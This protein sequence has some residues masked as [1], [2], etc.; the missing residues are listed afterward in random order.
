MDQKENL[1]IVEHGYCSQDMVNLMLTGI[2][3][4]NVFDGEQRFDD[5]V[6]KGIYNRQEFGYLT[7]YEAYGSI[8]VGQNYKNP[9]NEIYVINSESHY[10]VMFQKL[11]SHAGGTIYYYYDGLSNQETEI[12]LEI[13]NEREVINTESPLEK[14][15]YTKWKGPIEWTGSEVLL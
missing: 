10:S 9:E 5:L 4:S 13:K 12:K 14:C 3:S 2:A 11:S 1:L 8:L 6:L 7:L 15:I